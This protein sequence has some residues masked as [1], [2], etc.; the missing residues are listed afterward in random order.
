MAFVNCRSLNIKIARTLNDHSFEAVK[1][2]NREMVQWIEVFEWFETD[3][4]GN[5][6]CENFFF[7]RRWQANDIIDN[8]INI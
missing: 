6:Y 8:P 7:Q 1:L 4:F 2:K 5:L 3:S